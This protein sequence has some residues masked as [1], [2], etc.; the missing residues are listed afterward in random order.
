[1]C[2]FA[3]G[4]D[5]TSPPPPILLFFCPIYKDVREKLFP[6][7]PSSLL[8]LMSWENLICLLSDAAKD[9]ILWVFAGYAL[10]VGMCRQKYL[11]EK[12]QGFVSHGAV[13]PRSHTL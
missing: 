1:M 11:N 4:L 7:L 12:A 3:A 8:F 10:E 9:M 2:H 6:N 5:R 13:D